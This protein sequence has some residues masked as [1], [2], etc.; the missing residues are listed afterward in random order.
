[1]EKEKRYKT[2]KD[3]F[4][5]GAILQVYGSQYL[6]SVNPA[7]AISKVRFSL[8][9]LGTQG[10]ESSDIYLSVE[11]VRIFCNEIER[12]LAERKISED[13]G[14]YPTAYK[15][16][17]GTDGCKQLII[18]GGEK[19]VRIQ[20][21][22]RNDKKTDRKMSVIQFKDLQTLS[23]HFK[24]VAGL[25]QVSSGSYYDTLVKAYAKSVE[26]Q[27]DYYANYREELDADYR[28]ENPSTAT[29]STKAAVEIKEAVSTNTATTN[30][31]T[32]ILK[33]AF[34]IKSPMEPE[35]DTEGN[36]FYTALVTIEGKN[37]IVKMV[38]RP[39]CF[40]SAEQCRRLVAKATMNTEN[41]AGILIHC[42]YNKGNNYNFLGICA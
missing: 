42:K 33:G 31:S 19:G 4:E 41:S 28:E 40:D 24:L 18:G 12:G 27:S 22:I 39:S 6:L 29:G 20:I 13:K 30:S 1:M 16:V 36:L 8:V 17:K 37:K 5:S 25:V 23:F 21:I 11:D 9:K 14:A 38:F 10:K 15:W 2:D 26:K 35:E 7:F 32:E 3:M 34:R